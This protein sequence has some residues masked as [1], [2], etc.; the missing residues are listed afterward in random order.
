MVPSGGCL[1]GSSEPLWGRQLKS[2]EGGKETFL[3]TWHPVPQGADE[4]SSSPITGTIP[5]CP[6]DGHTLLPSATRPAAP[7]GRQR[8]R[9]AALPTH[10]CG[11]G[12]PGPEE[13]GHPLLDAGEAQV[14]LEGCWVDGG[15]VLLGEATGAVVG[16]GFAAGTCRHRFSSCSNSFK[17]RRKMWIESSLVESSFSYYQCSNLT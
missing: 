4:W 9:D 3:G 10:Y 5:V 16:T 2:P 17:I 1:E 14:W 6:P 11:R 12:G 7:R 15:R 8:P 13:R